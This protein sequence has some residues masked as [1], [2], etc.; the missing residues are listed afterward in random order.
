MIKLFPTNSE[1]FKINQIL[2]PDI[3]NHEDSSVE[4]SVRSIVA[5]VSDL[6]VRV[7]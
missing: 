6:I 3:E 7:V 1:K 4:P 5:S 2:P